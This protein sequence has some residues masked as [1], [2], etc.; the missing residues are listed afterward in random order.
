MSSAAQYVNIEE[1]VDDGVYNVRQAAGYFSIIVAL[2]QTI[3]LVSM[4]VHCNIAPIYINQM[5][6]IYPDVF[7]Y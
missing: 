7:D 6:G 5:L 4:M 3:V 2:A 1:M